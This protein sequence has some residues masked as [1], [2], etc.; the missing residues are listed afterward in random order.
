MSDEA[1]NLDACRNPDSQ[2][3]AECRGQLPR[4]CSTDNPA[5]ADVRD[6]ALHAQLTVG[7]ADRWPEIAQ[8]AVFWLD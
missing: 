5:T 7:P 8:K 6:A 1:V 4:R 3:V 2:L